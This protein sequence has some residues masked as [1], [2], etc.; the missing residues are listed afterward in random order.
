MSGANPVMVIGALVIGVAIGLLISA[1]L[2]RT[3]VA[4]YNK[5]AGG[6]SSPSSV[7][8]PAFGK[9]MGIILVTSS[10]QL[11]VTFLL[12]S[13][14][15]GVVGFL[16]SLVTVR[17]VTVPGE[18]GKTVTE[19]VRTGA[20]LIIGLP[21]NILIMAA[22]LSAMLP[23]T[24]RPAILVTLCYMLLVTLLVVVVVGAVVLFV[25]VVPGPP[26]VR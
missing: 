4:L 1:A 14:V 19:G 5:M 25:V 17:G 21:V 23:T 20:Q 9:G 7:P 13:L 3:A 12:T 10:V 16:I 15:S 26:G 8:E 22:W 11:V 24:F 6:A 2:L 18:A